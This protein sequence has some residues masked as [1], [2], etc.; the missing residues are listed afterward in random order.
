MRKNGLPVQINFFEARDGHLVV[1]LEG[2]CLVINVLAG[3]ITGDAV[4]FFSQMRTC[5]YHVVPYT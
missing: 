3:F 1:S 5:L 4:T 2:L